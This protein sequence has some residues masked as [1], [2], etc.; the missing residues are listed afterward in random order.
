M[1]ITNTKVVL[2]SLVAIF[3]IGGILAF[4]L[5]PNL[6]PVDITESTSGNAIGEQLNYQSPDFSLAS[7]SG[8]KFKLSD[9][10]G[11]TIILLF[12]HT[13]SVLAVDQL[14]TIDK[15]AATDKVNV[16]QAINVGEDESVVRNFLRRSGHT[17]SVLFDADNE[18][19]Q[20]YNISSYPTTFVIDTEGKIRSKMVGE[21]AASKLNAE[22]DKLKGSP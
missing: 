4:F 22:I 18:V 11:R 5:R 8:D 15:L 19:A 1:F 16:Y 17:M 6:E 12:W 9:Q 13:Q 14:T 7:V 10:K 21:V 2:N 20:V 3:I